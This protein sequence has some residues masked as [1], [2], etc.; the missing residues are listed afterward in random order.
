MGNKISAALEILHD[1]HQ[2]DY[3][4]EI[5]GVVAAIEKERAKSCAILN[6]EFD[7]LKDYPV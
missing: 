1:E 2:I 3:L 4:S 5:A 6:Q 7:C